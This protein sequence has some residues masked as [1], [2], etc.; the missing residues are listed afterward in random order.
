MSK[1]K[2]SKLSELEILLKQILIAIRGAWTQEETSKKLGFSALQVHRWESLKVTLSWT[3]FLKICQLRRAPIKTAF[4]KFYAHTGDLS[5]GATVLHLIRAGVS[6]KDLLKKTTIKTT[7]L[8]KILN[9]HEGPTM[10]EV[11]QIMFVCQSWFWEFW[12]EIVKAEKAPMIQNEI[13][14]R[15]RQISVSLRY[16]FTAALLEILGLKKYQDTNID[17]AQFLSDELQITLP[18]I[19]SALVTLTDAGLM[20]KLQNGKYQ[21]RLSDVNLGRDFQA[22]K[23]MMEYWMQRQLNL[24]KNTN[25]K[26]QGSFFSYMTV[27]LSEESFNEVRQLFLELYQKIVTI[28]KSDTHQHTNI[29][30]YTAGFVR[31]DEKPLR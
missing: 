11:L 22:A 10:M 21:V 7:R 6:Q 24:L 28:S 9:G 23:T 2:N 17:T 20:N 12:A 19:K 4:E 8:S 30:T 13:E 5:D 26:P 31:T 18:V 25:K 15:S 3:D 27:P 14:K 1:T 29:Y 16:P